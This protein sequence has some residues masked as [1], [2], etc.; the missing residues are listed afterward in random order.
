[1]KKLLEKSPNKRISATEALNHDF[2]S[3]DELFKEFTELRKSS[4]FMNSEECNS[5]LMLTT[6]NSRK[7]KM[8]L[9]D[10]SCLKFKM[11]ENLLTGRTDESG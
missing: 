10:D 3:K 2:F 8:M 11:K 9:R 6:D 5:P 1:M 4:S 7:K